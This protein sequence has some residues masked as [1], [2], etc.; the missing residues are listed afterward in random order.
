MIDAG[1]NRCVGGEDI[2]GLYDFQSLIEFEALFLHQEPDPIQGHESCM[3]FIHMADIRGYAELPEYLVTAD[4]KENFLL[5]PHLLVTAVKL[6][7]L[8]FTGT[9]T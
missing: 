8:M 9:V 5:D 3:P 4:A 2:A 6:K 7:L 1:L